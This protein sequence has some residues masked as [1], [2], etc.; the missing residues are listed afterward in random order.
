MNMKLANFSMKINILR[1][2]FPLFSSVV[3][4]VSYR[5]VQPKRSKAVGFAMPH[6]CTRRVHFLLISF[7]RHPVY[8]VEREVSQMSSNQLQKIVSGFFVIDK[9]DN[10]NQ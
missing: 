10:Q 9:F 4:S 2:P 3:F 5:V 1:T 7:F 6:P 8:I